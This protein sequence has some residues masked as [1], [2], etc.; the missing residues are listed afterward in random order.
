MIFEE[1]MNMWY[2]ATNQKARG[3]SPFQRTKETALQRRIPVSSAV[4]FFALHRF[5]RYLYVTG[6]GV[7]IFYQ[8]TAS[9]RSEFLWETIFREW[10]YTQIQRIKLQYQKGLANF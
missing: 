8:E 7:P 3:S 2:G 5:D 1:P 9:G 4:S 6:F 10:I